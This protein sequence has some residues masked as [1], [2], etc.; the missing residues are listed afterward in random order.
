MTKSR[1]V[2]FLFL[3]ATN[4]VV[5]FFFEINLTLEEMF[6]IHLFLFLLF[7]STSLFQNRICKSIKFLP[8]ISLGI[9]FLRIIGSVAFLIPNIF[10]K[11]YYSIHYIY[12]FFLIYFLLLFFDIFLKWKKTRKINT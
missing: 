5:L 9:N 7:L 2:F 12:N 4:L 10:N 6:K 3:L 1:L 8:F 11:K